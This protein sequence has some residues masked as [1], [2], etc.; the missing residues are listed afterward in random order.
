M[1]EAPRMTKASATRTNLFLDPALWKALRVRAL[2]ESTTATE[3]INRL[4]AAYL[5]KPQPRSSRRKGA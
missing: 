4:I 3:L 2:E 1:K 5:K